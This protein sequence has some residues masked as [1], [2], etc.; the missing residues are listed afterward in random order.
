MKNLILKVSLLSLFGFMLS[1]RAF[2]QESDWIWNIGAEMGAAFSNHGKD[3]YEPDYK[4]SEYKSGLVAG[5]FITYSRDTYAFTGKILLNQKGSK[6]QNGDVKERL[7]YIEI[8]VLARVYF[9]R[10]GTIKPNVFIGPSFGILT[11]A[12]WKRG[13]DDYESVE[14]FEDNDPNGD[15]D[16]YRDVYRIFDFG[17]SLG[18]GLSVK[19]A[20]ETYFIIETRYTHGLSD[21]KE[22]D[23]KG[24][25]QNTTVSVGFSFGI[26]N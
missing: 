5:G 2:S 24:N 18:L 25:N 26:S 14:N 11:G 23:G 4:D 7:N 20:N 16:S 9:N 21:F 15:W 3:P 12:Q 10:K 17:V 6:Y 8:P 13:D 19:V 22:R 1:I